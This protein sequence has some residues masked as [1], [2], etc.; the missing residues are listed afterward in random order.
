MDLFTSVKDS[1]AKLEDA[2]V[3]NLIIY[4]TITNI[5]YIFSNARV[6][7]AARRAPLGS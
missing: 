1:G 5:V 3:T 6:L 7:T 4:K 2:S